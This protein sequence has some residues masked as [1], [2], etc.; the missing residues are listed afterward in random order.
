MMDEKQPWRRRAMGWIGWDLGAKERAKA[1]A[2]AGK[3]ARQWSER[4]A[5]TMGLSW[6]ESDDALDLAREYEALS[7]EARRLASPEALSE[8]SD[9][10]R[11]R[12]ARLLDAPSRQ[13][14]S[15]AWR[16]HLRWREMMRCVKPRDLEVAAH[17]AGSAA[18][19]EEAGQ[20]SQGLVD[21]SRAGGALDIDD[22][23]ALEW[24]WSL[25]QDFSRLARRGEEQEEPGGRFGAGWRARAAWPWPTRAVEPETREWARRKWEPNLIGE[26]RSAF[27][28]E[29]ERLPAE[30][31]W[32]GV[33]RA[34]IMS[35]RGG[36]LAS[37][38]CGR[39]LLDELDAREQERMLRGLGE[40]VQRKAPSRL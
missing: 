8:V 30:A 11:S 40:P 5:S 10:L 14:A 38:R 9:G 12:A 7:E 36:D 18:W 3:M 26:E 1:S 17:E 37:T 24:A 34:L 22:Q 33:A 23:N 16:E 20:W 2:R 15:Q 31:T 28:R 27:E 21:L 4:V 39:C 19:W 32:L 35:Q 13:A 6:R 25:A 29:L